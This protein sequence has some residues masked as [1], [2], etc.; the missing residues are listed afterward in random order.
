MRKPGREGNA[1]ISARS[2]D[3]R[4]QG[5]NKEKRARLWAAPLAGDQA[6]R[7]GAIEQDAEG[8]IVLGEVRSTQSEIAARCLAAAMAANEAASRR[9]FAHG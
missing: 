1:Y 9:L 8:K 7:L 2:R 4:P 5:L 3:S 6:G